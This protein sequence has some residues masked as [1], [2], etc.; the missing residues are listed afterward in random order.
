VDATRVLGAGLL[1]YLVLRGDRDQSVGPRTR[2]DRLASTWVTATVLAFV[3]GAVV[4][5]PDPITQVLSLPPLF[6]ATF[7]ATHL[8]TTRVRPATSS[9]DN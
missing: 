6:V 9:V 3:V 2:A 8:W 7:A 1:V 5:P 4:T